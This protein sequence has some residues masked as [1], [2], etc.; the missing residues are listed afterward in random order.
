MS[1]SEE[2][3]PVVLS[4]VELCLSG[5]ISQS[6]SRKFSYKNKILLNLLEGFRVALKT[7]FGLDYT[8]PMLPS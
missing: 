4:I 7:F 1:N 8:Y 6:I 5:G 2:I 3:K